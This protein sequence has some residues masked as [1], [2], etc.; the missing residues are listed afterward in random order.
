MCA[1]VFVD[2][3]GIRSFAASILSYGVKLEERKKERRNVK[4][5]RRKRKKSEKSKKRK[6]RKRKRDKEEKRCRGG[7]AFRN[8]G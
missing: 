1:F 5:K 6:K 7:G 3:R 4:E 2:K 8:A